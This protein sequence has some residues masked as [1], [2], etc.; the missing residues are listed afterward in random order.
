MHLCVG[1]VVDEHIKLWP[2]LDSVSV[3]LAFVTKNRYVIKCIYEILVII[4]SSRIF[5]DGKTV[6]VINL[7]M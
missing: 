7:I 6:I 5:G 3:S 1:Y 2:G 4:I